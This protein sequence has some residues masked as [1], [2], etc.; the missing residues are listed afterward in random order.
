MKVIRDT[1]ATNDEFLVG[2]KGESPFDAGVI[3]L[4]YIQLMASKASFEDSFNPAMGLMSRYGLANNIFGA[5]MYY[6]RAIITNM[7]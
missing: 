5:E 4:P 7:P 1:F 3:Y 6:S 2:Y